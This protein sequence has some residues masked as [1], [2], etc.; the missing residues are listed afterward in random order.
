MPGSARMA[1]ATAAWS[2]LVNG[3]HQIEVANGLRR[4]R[5]EPARSRV[6]RRDGGDAALEGLAVHQSNVETTA[7]TEPGQQVNAV[8]QPGL[9]FGPGPSVQRLDRIHR[10]RANRRWTRRRA[11]HASRGCASGPAQECP[12]CPACP[13]ACC[14]GGP[15]NPRPCTFTHRLFNARGQPLANALISTRRPVSTNS[16]RSSVS[17]PS[18]R[19]RF[20]RSESGRRWRRPTPEGHRLDGAQTRLGSA[21]NRAVHSALAG[22]D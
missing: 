22:A 4:R 11:L 17:V 14:R 3:N 18:V 12:A 20:G 7:R 9:C 5:A 16:Q 10:L 2:G 19:D 1:S 15:P 13:V 8:E 21:R 6:A